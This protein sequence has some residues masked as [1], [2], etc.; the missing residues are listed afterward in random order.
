MKSITKFVG[1]DVSK[2][3]IA[4]AVAERGTGGARYLGVYPNTSEAIRK[5]LSRLGKP[6]ELYICYEAGVT[7]YGLA[8]FVKSLGVEC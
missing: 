7:G 8:R 6:E 2:D 3:K 1:L 5:L 4:A